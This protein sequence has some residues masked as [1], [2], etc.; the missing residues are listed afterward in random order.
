M[1]KG[2]EGKTL[3]ERGSKKKTEKGLDSDSFILFLSF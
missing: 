1:E 2:R 3:S